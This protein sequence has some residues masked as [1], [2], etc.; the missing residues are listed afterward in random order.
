MDGP[1]FCLAFVMVKDSF[2]VPAIFFYL[3]RAP[4]TKDKGVGDHLKN[5]L[6]FYNVTAKSI[7][8][9]FLRIVFLPGETVS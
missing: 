4:L 9:P 3:E 1:P 2:V 8:I 6:M 5:Q 7:G